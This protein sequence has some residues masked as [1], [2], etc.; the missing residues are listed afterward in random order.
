MSASTAASNAASNA[1]SIDSEAFSVVVADHT[2]TVT[3]LGPGKGNAQGPE[4]WRDCAPLFQKLSDDEN[5]RV[6]VVR[7]SGKH[8][9][10]GLDLPAM[11]G[12]LGPLLVPNAGPSERQ[13][14][15][16]VIRRMQGALSSIF[17][18]KKPVIAALH[19][20][21][22]GGGLD[23]AA[24]CDIRVCSKDARFSLREVKVGIVA[25][26]GSLQRLPHIIGEGATRELALTGRD[27][28]AARAHA[29]GL[30]SDVFADDDATFAGA[31]ALAAD[32]AAHS[33]LVVTGIKQVMNARIQGD[34]DAGLKSVASWN[35]AFLPSEDLSEAMAA[36]IEKRAPVFHG[37]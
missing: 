15:L 22:I 20:W 9:S 12:E 18:C 28:D 21:C 4:F 32:I 31:A 10:V 2:A 23:L 7:G 30:V 16:E 8:F 17:L 35:A 6:V 27:I 19:G 14:L 33:P 11:G 24:A 36:F 5:V 3:L 13:R 26:V 25:D 37:R 1:A 29:L 34:I